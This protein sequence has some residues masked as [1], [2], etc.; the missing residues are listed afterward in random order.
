[1]TEKMLVDSLI[2]HAASREDHSP[3]LECVVADATMASLKRAINSEN[4]ET[5]KS[6]LLDHS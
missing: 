4:E 5:S 3:L 6:H 2:S 1:M